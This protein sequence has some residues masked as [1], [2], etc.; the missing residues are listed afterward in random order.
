MHWDYWIKCAANAVLSRRG[1]NTA[2][3]DGKSRDYFKKNY[4]QQIKMIVNGLKGKSYTPQPVKRVK[5]PKANG[6]T[7]PLGIPTL[8]DRIV[9]EALRMILDPIYES[10]FQPCSY[11]FRKGRCTMDA[12][13]VIMPLFNTSAKRYYVIEGD[14]KS[15]FDTVNHRKLLNLLKQRIADKDMMTLIGKVLKSGIMRGKLFERT[16]SGVPQ[17]GIISPLFANVYLNEFDKWAEKKWHNLTPYERQK[18]R[19]AGRGNYRM[20]RYADDFVVV[21][22]DT[23][24]GVR[25][26][27][28][29][30]K[31]FLETELK[32]ALSEEKT[33]ITHVNKGFDFLGFQIKRVKPEGRWVVHLKPSQRTVDRVKSKIKDLTSRKYVLLDEVSRLTSLNSI[34]RGWCNYY[35]YTSLHRDIEQVSRYTWHR[36]HKWLL[37]KFKGSRKAQLVKDKTTNI[38]NR[39]RWKAKLCEGNKEIF[40]YQWLPTP[41]ELKRGRYKQKGKGGFDHPYIIRN[42]EDYPMGQKGVDESIY[43]ISLAN[44]RGEPL[45]MTERKLRV[46]LRDDFKCTQCD[47]IDNLQ[48][49]HTKGMKSHAMKHL[50]TLCFKCHQKEHLCARIN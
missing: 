43:D 50:V 4:D 25:Q 45:D 47:S 31:E 40:A 18:R 26:T 46:K 41:S 16:K 34:V 35:K 6:K 1:S 42:V 32:L 11:G 9:Q 36:Y 2:G 7:R 20:V 29:E 33:K 17:G 22:S 30:I 23:I 27:K 12:I 19:N 28:S 24:Q 13:A 44:T 38:H 49:H 37:K 21:S 15:Y 14:I 48:V 10:D 3:V 8:R 39:T 5:I